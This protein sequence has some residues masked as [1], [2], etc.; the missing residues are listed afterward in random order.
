MALSLTTAELVSRLKLLADYHLKANSGSTTTVVNT[1]LV[2]E[3]NISNS[4]ICFIS[5]LNAPTDRVVT[6]FYTET[7][8]VGFGALDNAVVNTDEFC[9]VKRGY[10]SDVV[11][12]E[13]AMRNHFRNMGY[14]LDLFLTSSHIKEAHVYKTLEL[15]CGSL[16]NDANADDVYY[17]HYKRF[18][19]LYET[20]TS[21]LIADYDANE[22]GAISEDE[23]LQTMNYGVFGR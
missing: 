12:A 8:T 15:I 4:L 17:F 6:S 21:T 16:M 23:E 7:G 9:I 20:E 14:D 1:S 5:G 19:E 3:S 18:K 13:Q 2:G 10:Q 11:Q 22:D